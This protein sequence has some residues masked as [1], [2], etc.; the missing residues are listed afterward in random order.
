MTTQVK[1]AHLA[2][3]FTIFIWATTFVSTKILL[4]DFQPIEILFFRFVMGFAVLV[5]IYPQHLKIGDKKQEVFFILAGLSGVCLYFLLENIALTYTQ[6]SN[7]G[8]IISVAPFFT[9]IVTK[10]FMKNDEKLSLKFFIGFVI[11]I[12]GISLI[13]FGGNSLEINP[14]GDFLA[15]LAAIAWAFYSVLTRKISS[16]GYNTIQTT[17]RVFAY[18]ILFMIPTLFFF[19]FNWDLGRFLKPVNLLNILYLGLGASALC[20]V[21]WGFAV[22]VL[23][24]V[25]TSVYIYLVPIVTVITSV[26]ILKEKVTSLGAVGILLTLLGLIISE[27]KVREKKEK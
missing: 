7:V 19:D 1:T 16:F 8:I 25:K 21:T 11:A 24:A 15:L 6:A 12:T 5:L 2:A 14:M 17:R 3:I 13:S 20:F 26:L 4:I 22:K 9:A 18:G 10:L 27:R 23:G